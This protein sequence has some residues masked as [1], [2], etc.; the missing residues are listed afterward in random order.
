MSPCRGNGKLCAVASA[1]DGVGS[2]FGLV[3]VCVGE[4]EGVCKLLANGAMRCG[5]DRD[6]AWLGL[7]S[8]HW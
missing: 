6:T 8:D 5:T 1:R 2:V 7:C 3:R 4:G